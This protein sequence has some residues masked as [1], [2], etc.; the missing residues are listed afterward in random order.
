MDSVKSFV[1]GKSTGN[2]IALALAMGAAGFYE[3]KLSK[4]EMVIDEPVEGEEEVIVERTTP[5]WKRYGL[6]AIVC[7][8]I[9]HIIIGRMSSPSS[10][11]EPT[12]S[13][14]ARMSSAASDLRKTLEDSPDV[15][16]MVKSDTVPDFQ[17]RVADAAKRLREQIAQTS[18]KPSHESS[19][20]SMAAQ[21]SAE[22]SKFISENS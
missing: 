4:M 17:T 9:V 5:K 8:I 1:Y 12:S 20:S 11:F 19:A 15:S 18:T 6:L 3:Y 7:V 14:E 22:I 16:P 21:A 2:V 10:S 13:F